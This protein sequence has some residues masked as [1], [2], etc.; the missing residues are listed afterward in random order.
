[1]KS[2]KGMVLLVALFAINNVVASQYRLSSRSMAFL[3]ESKEK[4]MRT[5]FERGLMREDWLIDAMASILNG[6]ELTEKN[7]DSVIQKLNQM[8]DIIVGEPLRR[9]QKISD[10]QYNAITNAI[11]AQISTF[12][13]SRV[14]QLFI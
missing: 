2:F 14:G 8:T 3:K 11:S 1:M 4:G 13:N 9:N 5:Q 12:V 10:A 6:E 7:K